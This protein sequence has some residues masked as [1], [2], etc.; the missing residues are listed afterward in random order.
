M[1]NVLLPDCR[2]KVRALPK[3]M[4]TPVSAHV[5]A[6]DSPASVVAE[7]PPALLTMLCDGVSLAEARTAERQETLMSAC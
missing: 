3:F 6:I 5:L 7:T 2:F 4:A 1:P